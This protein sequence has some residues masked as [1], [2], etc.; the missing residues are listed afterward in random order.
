MVYLYINCLRHAIYLFGSNFQV[1]N[2]GP[3]LCQNIKKGII[4]Q[5]VVRYNLG[6]W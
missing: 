1:G 4:D 2:N 3:N 6:G 5:S